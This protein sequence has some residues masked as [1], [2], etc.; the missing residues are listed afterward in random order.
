MSGKYSS[1]K[2]MRKEKYDIPDDIWMVHVA[3]EEDFTE[4]KYTSGQRSIKCFL[5]LVVHPCDR[6]EQLISAAAQQSLGQGRYRRVR[7]AAVG[8][9]W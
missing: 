2:L 8:S 7:F 1:H 6:T 3:E 4:I 9:F 5:P